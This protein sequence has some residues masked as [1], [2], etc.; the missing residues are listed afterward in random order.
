MV[1]KTEGKNV[2]LWGKIYGTKKD[3]YIAEG[4]KEAAAGEPSPELEAR[5]TGVNKYAYWVTDSVTGDW[6]ELPNATPANIKLARQIKHIFSGNLEEKVI[7]NPYFEGTEK[8]LLRAQIARVCQTIT[9]VPAGLYKVNEENKAEVVDEAEEKKKIVP[10]DELTKLESWQH[11]CPVLLKV[12]ILYKQI[13]YTSI[14]VWKNNT[15]CSSSKTRCN[16]RGN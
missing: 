1:V 11:Y 13:Q 16:R 9:L 6:T 3:Y 2:R 14:L 8:E 10:F 5:G 12:L 15:R 7:T 4:E